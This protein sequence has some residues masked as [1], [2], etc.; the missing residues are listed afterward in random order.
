MLDIS[1]YDDKELALLIDNRWNES[2]TLWQELLKIKEENLRVHKNN[3]K[4]V[5]T[6]T[7]KQAKGRGIRVC[8]NME[9]LISGLLSDLPKPNVVPGHDTPGS[10]ELSKSIEAIETN[11]YDGDHTRA[12]LRRALRGLFFTRLF[13]IKPYWDAVQNNFSVTWVNPKNV[14]I[15]KRASKEV[16]ADAIIEEVE[17]TFPQMLERFPK[18]KD[19]ILRLGGYPEGEEGE[20]KVYL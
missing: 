8:R 6:L 9:S 12:V 16:E 15:S 14:R 1:K 4:W 3:P 7:G 13:L 5:G 11:Q 2:D 19:V 20:K 17:S 18:K 10:K